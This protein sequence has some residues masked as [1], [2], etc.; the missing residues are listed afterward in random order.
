MALYNKEQLLEMDIPTD[1]RILLSNYD[2]CKS[3]LDEMES[4]F[5]GSDEDV[6][7][8]THSY[9]NDEDKKR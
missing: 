4:R 7:L 9:L 8:F 5:F 1:L 6:S 3:L 2:C